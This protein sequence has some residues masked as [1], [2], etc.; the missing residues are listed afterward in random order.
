MVVEI[1]QLEAEMLFSTIETAAL[2]QQEDKQLPKAFQEDAL[3][4]KYKRIR[5][6]R[7]QIDLPEYT[8]SKLQDFFKKG[9]ELGQEIDLFEKDFTFGITPDRC[10]NLGKEPK[11][12]RI[13]L[14]A[15]FGL[16]VANGVESRCDNDQ[17]RHLNC[18]RLDSLCIQVHRQIVQA[19]LFL[20]KEDVEMLFT[21]DLAEYPQGNIWKKQFSG[22]IGVVRVISSVDDFGG[23]LYWPDVFDDLH[24]KIDILV[25]MPGSKDGHCLQVK[26]SISDRYASTLLS[27]LRSQDYELDKFL[28]GCEEFGAKAPGNWSPLF[29]FVGNDSRSRYDLEG[30]D[31]LYDML[32]KQVYYARLNFSPAQAL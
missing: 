1:R 8:I 20:S 3:G 24:G 31:F 30:S 7:E 13:L 14:R 2:S 11:P 4:A 10:P 32:K 19:L 28:R 18:R 27:L 6:P 9:Q 22:A 12:L 17:L 5:H 15:V 23:E 16:G 29:V 25:R 21:A 26:S